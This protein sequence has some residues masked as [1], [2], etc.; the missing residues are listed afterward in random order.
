MGF[1]DANYNRQGNAQSGYV[2]ILAGASVSWASKQQSCPT[3]S[4]TE[5]ELVAAVTATQEAI[6]L[7]RLLRELNHPQDKPTRIYTDNS[8]LVDLMKTEKRLGNSKHFNRLAWLRHQ[9]RRNIVDI[10]LIPATMQTADYLTK[11][12]P[13]TAF[14]QCREDTGLLPPPGWKQDAA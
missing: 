9:V 1:T 12:L 3:L 2:F 14:E 10:V 4:S 11:V 13:R 5:A 8:A 7:R 6:Y